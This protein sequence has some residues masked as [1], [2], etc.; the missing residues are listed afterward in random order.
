MPELQN[1]QLRLLE[2]TQQLTKHSQRQ[3]EILNQFAV[4]SQQQQELLGQLATQSQRQ[5]RIL[6]QL[7]GYSLTNESEHLDF[8]ERLRALQLRVQRLERDE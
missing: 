1:S 2:Q 5:Q 8:E 3:E 4:Q 7:I 6:D